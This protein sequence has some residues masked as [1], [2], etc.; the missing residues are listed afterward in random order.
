MKLFLKTGEDKSQLNVKRTGS[1][2]YIVEKSDKH[3]D[4]IFTKNGVY[5][6]GK[7]YFLNTHSNLNGDLDSIVLDGEF[8]PVEVQ[9]IDDRKTSQ[10]GYSPDAGKIKAVLAGK[11]ISMHVENNQKVKKGDLLL[12][13]EAMKMENEIRAPFNGIISKVN[14]ESGNLVIKDEILVE[15]QEIK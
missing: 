5:V 11:I 10:H 15:L 4:I 12:V 3:Y 2:N 1:S 7:H 8:F 13:L 6:N 9:K 14:V